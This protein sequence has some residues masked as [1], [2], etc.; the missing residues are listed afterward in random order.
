MFYLIRQ[1]KRLFLQTM[2]SFLN[3]NF[4]NTHEH[5]RVPLLEQDIESAWDDVSKMSD[6]INTKGIDVN[7]DKEFIKKFLKKI[8]EKND[9]QILEEKDVNTSVF[10]S[11]RIALNYVINLIKTQS[12]YKDVK[13]KVFGYTQEELTMLNDFL[14]A[15]TEVFKV[16]QEKIEEVKVDV[17][18][19][20][21]IDELLADL[22]NNKSIGKETKNIVNEDTLHQAINQVIGSWVSI[23]QIYTNVTG[24]KSDFSEKGVRVFQEMLVAQ[25]SLFQQLTWANAW[26]YAL[27]WGKFDSFSK[28][29]WEKIKKWEKFNVQLTDSSKLSPQTQ[30]ILGW[31]ATLWVLIVTWGQVVVWHEV[32]KLESDEFIKKIEK[33]EKEKT[34]WKWFGSTLW[35][36]AL[37]IK[38]AFMWK[39]L[40]LSFGQDK[41]SV[42]EFKESIVNYSKEV[43]SLKTDT[44]VESINN[45]SLKKVYPEALKMAQN[46]WLDL[47]N[48][49]QMKM[50]QKALIQ[51]YIVEEGYKNQGKDWTFRLWLLFIGGNRDSVAVDTKATNNSEANAVERKHTQRKLNKKEIGASW[52]IIEKNATSYNYT[53]PTEIQFS[54]DLKKY[55]VFVEKSDVIPQNWVYTFNK[56]QSVGFSFDGEKYVLSFTENKNQATVVTVWQKQDILDVKSI[57]EWKET[58]KTNKI[59]DI[60]Y[61][62]IGHQDPKKF[63]P[64]LRDLSKWDLSSAKVRLEWLVKKEKNK[65]LKNQLQLLLGDFNNA[66]IWETYMSGNKASRKNDQ[67]TQ[68]FINK[69]DIRSLWVIKAEERLAKKNWFPV[70]SHEGKF[71]IAP[72]EKHTPTQI[73]SLIPGQELTSVQFMT[74]AVREW[75]KIKTWV[76]RVS[77][78]D[79]S[80][81]ISQKM[82][83]ITD[84][85]SKKQVVEWILKSAHESRGVKV[86]L[87]KLNA[88]LALNWKD[89]V[90]LENY[91][92]YLVDWDLTKLWVDWL[93]LQAGKETKFVEARAMVAGN[94]CMNRVYAIAYPVFE[95]WDASQKVEAPMVVDYSAGLNVQ[96]VTTQENPIW[97][98]PIAVALRN[99]WGRD[100]GGG[101][102]PEGTSTP[103][104]T[105][106]TTWWANAWVVAPS[107]WSTT[108]TTTAPWFIPPGS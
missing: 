32:D 44:N 53:I 78:F 4:D 5:Q 25:L 67:F 16:S 101:N 65:K 54:W 69:K 63:W 73:T 43:M 24:K 97:I 74:P 104:A 18:T 8:A 39:R 51:S 19:T 64:F 75:G 60:L 87:D 35:D 91:K 88:F 46:I 99:A 105:W 94:V 66:S 41:P 17:E 13:S 52:I 86:Q 79:G 33:E 58:Y 49:E 68:D 2:I 108:V 31:L 30:N 59:P 106:E 92:N 23:E 26:L 37:W 3:E 27:L 103:G 38:D 36:A 98:N 61:D 28:E 85:N 34:E 14:G 9:A 12:E 82:E 107:T 89:K 40:S 11:E 10:S 57:R 6:L 20:L 48:P 72:T 22:D 77:V 62:I 42:D 1:Q 95:L 93:Q 7:K 100:S 76:H 84:L 50:L 45:E 70:A 90:S 102:T 15:K 71:T 83:Y 21:K 96:E 80:F 56:P 55:P 47:N 81:A 29:I